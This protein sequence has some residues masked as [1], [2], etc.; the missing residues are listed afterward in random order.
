MG[1]FVIAYNQH[2]SAILR[3]ERPEAANFLSHLSVS[4]SSTS[5]TVD[6]PVQLDAWVYL[7]MQAPVE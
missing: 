1:F 2:V 4:I 5:L 7:I 3:V 6:L